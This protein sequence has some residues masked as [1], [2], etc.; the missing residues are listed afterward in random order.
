MAKNFSKAASNSKI[1]AAGKAN[2]EKAN[3]ITIKMISNENLY[4]YPKNGEDLNDTQDLEL[5][6]AQNGFTD[7]IE[8]TNYGR[9]K[10]CYTILSGHRRRAAGVKCNMKTFPCIVRNFENDSDVYN[11]VLLANSQRDSSKDPLLFCKR[12]KMH[13]EYLKEMNFKGSKREEIAKRL[14]ISVQQA[15]RYNQMNSIIMPVW[16]LVREEK[17]GM[18]SVLPMAK[19]L[20]ESFQK[21]IYEIFLECYNAGDRLSREMCK[22]I[23]DGYA[24][25]KHSYLEIIQIEM[26]EMEVPESKKEDEEETS[27]EESIKKAQQN[28]VFI[29]TEPGETKEP[30]ERNRN[31]ET[32]YDFSHRDGMDRTSKEK[33][34]ES[35]RLTDDDLKAI[36]LKKKNDVKKA[37]NEEE[38]EEENEEDYKLAK[39]KMQVLQMNDNEINAIFET[40]KFNGIVQGYVRNALE[41]VDLDV[42]IIERVLRELNFSYSVIKAEDAK[43]MGE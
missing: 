16:D 12:Y 19:F 17:V 39:Y 25:G 34:I 36:E 41:Y 20:S 43:K 33:E 7:P 37:E 10:N 35:E 29:N 23:I 30:K 21:E 18:S 32:N 1:E 27:L 4:D 28:A 31:D 15:D 2:E 13:E 8:V 6:I 38:S 40:G 9:E 3:L 26:S 14:G 5:S 42:E 11:Y 24:S 22:K